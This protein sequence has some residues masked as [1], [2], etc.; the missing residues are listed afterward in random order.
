MTEK[1]SEPEC[2]DHAESVGISPVFSSVSGGI[3]AG[4]M[5]TKKTGIG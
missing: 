3:D 2:P 1:L 5:S 4:Y